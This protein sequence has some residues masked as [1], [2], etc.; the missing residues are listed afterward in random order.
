MRFQP[1][2]AKSVYCILNSICLA[3]RRLVN[4]NVSKPN[5]VE[6]YVSKTVPN[7]PPIC[8]L[9]I[10]AQNRPLKALKMWF[11]DSSR[12]NLVPIWPGI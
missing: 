12:F 6:F 5:P 2:T 3:L 4:L 1:R 7:R 10:L 9:L 8:L 11:L